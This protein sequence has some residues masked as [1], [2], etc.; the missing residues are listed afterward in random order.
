MILRFFQWNK[1]DFDLQWW[2][3]QEN[4]RIK[5]G[6][7]I[8][9]EQMKVLS[10]MNIPD[11]N[12]FCLICYSETYLL[13]L[14]C[15]HHFCKFCWEDYL[16][17]K[18][19]DFLIV[20]SAT[21][22]Q[23]KCPLIVPEGI[24]YKFLQ[25]NSVALEKLQKAIYKNFISNNK[26]N[27]ICPFRNCNLLIEYLQEDS[28]DI[29]CDC[30]YTFCFNCEKE[31]HHPVDCKTLTLWESK[32]TSKDQDDI[33][34]KAN[35][36][37]CPHCGTKIIRSFG[38]NYMLCDPKASGCGK[39]FCYVC[40]EDWE[41]H[42]QDHFDCNKYTPDKKAKD[43]KKAKMKEKLK[44]YKHFFNRYINYKSAVKFAE[45][46]LQKIP[47]IQNLISVKGIP[48]NQLGFLKDAVECVISTKLTLMNTYI[49]GYYLQEGK[50]NDLFVYNQAYLERNSD[51]LHLLIEYD[52]IKNIINT[53]DHVELKEKFDQHKQKIINLTQASKKFQSG[54][55]RYVET[56][57]MRNLINL[58][59]D[60]NEDL[61]N[62]E[63]ANNEIDA[64]SSET[65]DK[66]EG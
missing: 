33:W 30:G 47:E 42:T 15:G 29:I 40:E 23:E 13:A 8:S 11:S 39:A 49:L 59:D 38:C 48:L 32:N 43:D 41:K 3:E 31:S 27:K 22:P 58:N 7:A 14:S 65:N 36:K 57:E 54:M 5:C 61:N 17:Y 16:K 64:N 60:V 53:I 28:I 25:N 2:D 44:K 63:N 19:E 10:N 12:K 45:R 52:S 34:V 66:N 4:I 55:I 46:L 18:T 50:E 1:E 21:C 56:P 37:T 20:L 51:N 62:V 6:L 26:Y 9:D 35:C 24:F